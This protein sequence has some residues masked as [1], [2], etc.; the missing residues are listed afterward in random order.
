M[1]DLL[2]RSSVLLHFI[3][4]FDGI[5]SNSRFSSSKARHCWSQKAYW[6]SNEYV[7][8]RFSWFRES[9]RKFK[10]CGMEQMWS[11]LLKTKN[12]TNNRYKIS[13][14]Y[15]QQVQ[16]CIVMIFLLYMLASPALNLCSIL[17]LGFCCLNMSFAYC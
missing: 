4:L 16:Q 17:Y 15:Q 8:G 5:S 12:P 10:Q 6:V 3:F 11:R 13:Y 2:H 7:D 9:E 14:Y 1:S